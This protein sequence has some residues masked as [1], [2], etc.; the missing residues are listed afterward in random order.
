M[1]LFIE[2]YELKTANGYVY[3][4]MPVNLDAKNKANL[5][6][7]SHR[8]WKFNT[9]T[10]RVTEIKNIREHKPQVN[11]AEFLK[12]QLMASPVPFS[13]YY[14]DLEEIKRRRAELEAE[15]SSTTD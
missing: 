3:Y 8:I 13:D 15:K 9:K 10:N 6:G 2:Y 5:D 11:R 12:I 4:F 7:Q 1:V 14:L